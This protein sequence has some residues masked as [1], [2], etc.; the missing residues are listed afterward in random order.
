MTS[1][2]RFSGSIRK[3]FRSAMLGEQGRGCPGYGFSKL[4]VVGVVAVL[5]LNAFFACPFWVKINV[6]AIVVLAPL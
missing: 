6:Q 5:V 3:I 2:C 1:G 4:L